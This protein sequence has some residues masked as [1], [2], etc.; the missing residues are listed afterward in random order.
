MTGVKAESD[1]SAVRSAEATVSAEDQD[2]GAE[3]VCWIPAHAD[4]LTET[5]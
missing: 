5:K 4:V 3:D 2:L 1:R